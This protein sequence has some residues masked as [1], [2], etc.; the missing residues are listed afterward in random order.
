MICFTRVLLPAAVL[1]LA[2]GCAARERPRIEDYM[3]RETFESIE[4]RR[5]AAFPGDQEIGPASVETCVRIALDNNPMN[6]AARE[7]IAAAREAI[8]EA[9][10]AYLPYVNVY[11]AFSRLEFQ[12]FRFDD[13]LLFPSE[14]GPRNSYVAAPVATWRVF[15][16]GGRRARLKA[17][18]ARKDIARDE[19]ARIRQDIALNVHQA[20]YSLQVALDAQLAAEKN[21]AASEE[22]R[23]LARERFEAGAAAEV[24]VL[25][26][27]VGVSSAKLSLV[28]ARSDARVARGNLNAAMGL[29]PE[30][31]LDVQPPRDE[32]VPPEAMDVGELFDQA[33]RLRPEVRQALGRVEIARRS[34]DEARSSYLPEVNL[35]GVY[36][37]QGPDFPP[38]GRAWLYGA[39]MRVPVFEG[40]QRG[41]KM[42]RTKAQLAQENANTESLVL[43]V[44]SEVWAAYERLREAYEALEAARVVVANADENLR[45]A[46]ER[47]KLQAVTL[48]DLLDAQNTL[49]R[50][51][52]SLIQARWEY[53]L[54]GAV[55]RR[56]VGTLIV[57]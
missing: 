11:L 2:A 12:D 34:V 14:L 41:Y 10:S 24:D 15:D 4:R 53:Y 27:N 57:E 16:G 39:Y 56:A 9:R 28:R 7:G 50:G 37:Q 26:A 42:R 43:Q 30:M 40:L 21:L 48:S 13:G 18:E 46:S 6:R 44:R 20:F 38:E 35:F 52:V 19:A 36:L 29:P 22:H 54:A 51:E 1:L 55:L 31:P 45:A 8:G 3:P 32:L 5:M 23:R 33:L 25:H 17:A 49:V 47:Y